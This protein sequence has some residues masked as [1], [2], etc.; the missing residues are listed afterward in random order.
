L[1]FVRYSSSDGAERFGVHS[2]GMVTDLSTSYA[3]FTE[4]LADGAGVRPEST[5]G[6]RVDNMNL[7]P[8]VST[9]SKILCMAINYHSHIDEQHS[10]QT[11]EPILFTKFYSS[12]TGPFA[13]IPRFTISEIMDYEGEIAVVIG[14]RTKDVGRPDAWGHVLGYTLLN[15]MSA[16]SLFRVPQGNGTMLDWF[17]CKTIDRSTPVG[18]WI[19]T[20]D[21]AGD[22]AHLRIETFLNGS[23]VQSA[24][25][26]D[27][28]FDVP[29]IIEHVSSRVTLE[30][31]DLISTG[32]P[33]GVGVARKRTLEKG[34]LVKVQAEGIGHLENRIV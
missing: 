1:K 24:G 5:Q 9:A 34:D 31:G 21:E 32:T 25:P 20:K 8:P 11:E 4:M 16:R 15:D 3:D 17:S 27:M 19:V 12:L 33:A 30:P 7:L 22:F 14:R 13:E 6:V 10:A 28:V 2:N 26:S 23:K 29:K 18:P